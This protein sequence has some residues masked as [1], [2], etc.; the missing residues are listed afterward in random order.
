MAHK[1]GETVRMQSVITDENGN[2]ATPSAV[3]VSLIDPA[4]TTKVDAQ[5]ASTDVTGTYYHD[6]DVPADAETGFWRYNFKAT[7][8]DSRVQ[9]EKEDF[10]VVDPI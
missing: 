7:S 8:S 10:E 9:I 5:S 4:G 2:A 1:L 3:V 6:Y